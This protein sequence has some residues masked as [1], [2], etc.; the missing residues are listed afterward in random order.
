M[1]SNDT[2]FN[3]MLKKMEKIERNPIKFVKV[4]ITIHHNV[5]VTV[6]E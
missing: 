3:H 2:E 6:N 4:I 5:F 1:E